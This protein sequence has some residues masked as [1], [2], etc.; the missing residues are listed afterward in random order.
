MK[1]FSTK[2]KAGH[3]SHD[4]MGPEFEVIFPLLFGYYWCRDIGRLGGCIVHESVLA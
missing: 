4:N 2:Y 1:I 3:R